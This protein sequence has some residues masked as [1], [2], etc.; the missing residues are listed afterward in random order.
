MRLSRSRV[1][2]RISSRKST[3]FS[4]V[5]ARVTLPVRCE[6]QLVRKVTQKSG[7]VLAVGERHRYRGTE[8]DL[9]VRGECPSTADSRRD[10]DH[11]LAFGLLK[12]SHRVFQLQHA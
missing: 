1:C 11:A 5:A 4:T 8:N 10:R 6:R 3:T 9:S 2:R 12:T 7:G